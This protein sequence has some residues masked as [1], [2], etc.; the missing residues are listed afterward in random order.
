MPDNAVVAVVVTD[1]DDDLFH[2]YHNKST[3]I[4]KRRSIA[5][6]TELA[7]NKAVVT[8]NYWFNEINWLNNLQ[9]Q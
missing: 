6:Y 7:D 1:D 3:S 4:I 8:L 5:V 9:W 2:H